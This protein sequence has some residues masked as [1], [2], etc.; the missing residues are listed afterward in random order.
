[1]DKEIRLTGAVAT[2][3]DRTNVSKDAKAI[4]KKHFG[5]QLFKTEI[6]KT[7]RVE[8]ANAHSQ[9]VLAFAPK[10]A[11]AHAYQQLAKEVLKHVAR[12]RRGRDREA[13]R[14]GRS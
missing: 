14:P 2:M 13:H 1:M 8:E 9:S 7:V 12:H 11:A 5:T 4:L 10:S 6:P 3:M